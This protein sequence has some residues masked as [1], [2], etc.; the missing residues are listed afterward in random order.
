MGNTRSHRFNS[1]IRIWASKRRFN[2]LTIAGTLV[3]LMNLY[4]D[5]RL[6]T[7]GKIN[8]LHLPCHNPPPR[9]DLHLQRNL[10]P[11]VPKTCSLS[12]SRMFHTD[13][14]STSASLAIPPS[15][16]PQIQLSL[17]LS[18]AGQISPGTCGLYG[19]HKQG[20]FPPEQRHKLPTCPFL[21][22]YR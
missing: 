6:A 15:P 11:L 22:L 10:L 9:K 17:C 21:W 19:Y 8:C 5:Q 4:S 2:S 3:A 16:L 20:V 1:V 18:K 12:H 7:S 13:K 14:S